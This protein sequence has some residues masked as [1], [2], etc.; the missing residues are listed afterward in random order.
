M[1]DVILLS[2]IIRFKGRMTYTAY[3][4]LLSHVNKTELI[5]KLNSD[6]SNFVLKYTNEPKAKD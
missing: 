2:Y 6:Y 5:Q 1:N 3:Y 4:R